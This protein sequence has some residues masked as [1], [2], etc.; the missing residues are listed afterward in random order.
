MLKLVFEVKKLCVW[1][2][3]RAL[4]GKV[5]RIIWTMTVLRYANIDMKH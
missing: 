2:L 4:N 1:L 5:L 3:V